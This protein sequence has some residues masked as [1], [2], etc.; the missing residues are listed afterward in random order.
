MK[1]SLNY[2]IR[3][4]RINSEGLCPIYLRYTYQ[5]K[6]KNL[7]IKYSISPDN[8]DKENSI[9]KRKYSNFNF[10][11]KRLSDYESEVREKLE[12]YF[13]T[14]ETYPSVDNIIVVL[15]NTKI[16]KG[17]KVDEPLKELYQ[18]FVNHKRSISDRYNSIKNYNSTW[19]KWEL[20]E[21]GKSK[22]GLKD[23]D[24]KTITDFYIFLINNGL[25]R[26]SI[27]KYLKIFKRFLDYLYE[28]REL[29]VSKSYK[30]FKI[31]GPE[32]KVFEVLTIEELEK[33]KSC[34]L[35]SHFISDD[36]N[37]VVLTER[38]KLIGRIMIFLCSTGLSYV[39][40]D[41]LTIHDLYIDN[42]IFGGNKK[43]LNIKIDRKKLN[44]SN[45]CVIPILDNTIDLVL[46]VMGMDI[47]FYDGSNKET[48]LQLKVKLLGSLLDDFKNNKYS[49]KHHPRLFPK[50]LVQHFNKEIKDVLFKIG[51]TN[52]VK[53]IRHIK[54]N[55]V[56]TYVS[57][58]QLISS[59][60]GRR[61]YITNC[62]L[63]GIR[64]HI[65]MKTTGHKKIGTLLKYNRESESNIFN[66]YERKV[67]K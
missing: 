29:E 18:E 17:N 25:Q 32:D 21:E 36:T 42:E 55:N 37:K 47:D 43:Y 60:T 7:P 35:Y 50:V 52:S 56:E 20:F 48:D 6:W 12:K 40:F 4:D 45:V 33:I 64:P 53:V 14:Y 23:I 10:L 22:K 39:D 5:R 44:T 8:W 1:Y 38:E 11:K 15:K 13:L 49:E 34:V 62:L 16:V 9:V 19:N 51:I 66:E 59:H 46:E 24:E 27:V 41:R 30:R 2:V 28:Y 63:Q 67:L 31:K 61:S 3:T 65:L 57:K 54:G 58:S 26:S